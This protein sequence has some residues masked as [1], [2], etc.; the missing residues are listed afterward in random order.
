MAHR[1]GIPDLYAVIKIPNIDFNAF[2]TNKIFAR[3][4]SGVTN[5]IIDDSYKILPCFDSRRLW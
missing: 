5:T 3:Y 4:L 1:F 2:P